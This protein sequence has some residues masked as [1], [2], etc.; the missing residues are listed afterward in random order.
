MNTMHGD[1]ELIGY[2]DCV[3][4]VRMIRYPLQ[5]IIQLADTHVK[6]RRAMQASALSSFPLFV[7]TDDL[8]MTKSLHIVN[9]NACYVRRQTYAFSGGY[10]VYTSS[11]SMVESRHEW[12]HCK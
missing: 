8:V 9:N 4:P 6:V 7:L 10:G 12:K 5:N 1:A 11:S 2:P 3:S